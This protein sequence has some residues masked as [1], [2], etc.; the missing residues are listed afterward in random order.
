MNRTGSW[1]GVQEDGNCLWSKM[2]RQAEFE[3]IFSGMEKS[4]DAKQKSVRSKRSLAVRNGVSRRWERGQVLA[5]Y[6]LMMT[7]CAV[8]SLLFL[9]LLAACSL[10]GSRLVSLVAW[11]PDP[12]D[13]SQMETIMNGKY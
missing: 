9:V 6:A 4:W 8:F 3:E 12:P 13:R 11:E 7:V 10:Y 2:F 5:E 1:H